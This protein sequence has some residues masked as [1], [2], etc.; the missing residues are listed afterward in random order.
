MS[1][2]TPAIES[3]RPYLQMRQLD[4]AVEE[5][6]EQIQQPHDDIEALSGNSKGPAADQAPIQLSRDLDSS[7]NRGAGSTSLILEMKAVETCI[8][9]LSELSQNVSES[10]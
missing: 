6:P 7:Y 1:L 2:S 3:D 4:Y 5:I 8:D 10:I 9:A